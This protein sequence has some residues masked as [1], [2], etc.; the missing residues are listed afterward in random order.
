MVKPYRA[1][2]TSLLI[3]AE[4]ESMFAEFG[5]TVEVIEE[6]SGNFTLV[7]RDFLCRE[8]VKIE[9]TVDEW[10]ELPGAIDRLVGRPEGGL[11]V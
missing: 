11:D 8:I 7:V 5:P 3:S 2:K 4:G 6:I 9:S 10:P 1:R